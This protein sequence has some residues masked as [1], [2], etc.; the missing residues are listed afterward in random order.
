MSSSIR[1][2]IV[3]VPRLEK[4]LKF[5]NLRVFN[6]RI[7]QI[8]NPS[9]NMKTI[10]LRKC[11][12][13]CEIVFLDDLKKLIITKLQQVSELEWGIAYDKD[14]SQKTHACA[15]I[16]TIVF[17][18][19]RHHKLE[20]SFVNVKHHYSLSIMVPSKLFSSWVP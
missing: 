15:K 17:I 19:I 6:I 14:N 18:L 5:T 2:R 13:I 3:E 1:K 16:T 7:V 8:N 9:R 11:V 20:R 12:L 10:I 4:H